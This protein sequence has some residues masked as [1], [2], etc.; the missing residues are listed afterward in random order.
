MLPCGHNCR[1]LS[2]RCA[3]HYGASTHQQKW[4]LLSGLWVVGLW[5]LALFLWRRGLRRYESAGS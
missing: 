3:K 4:L 1:A 2:R 5:A